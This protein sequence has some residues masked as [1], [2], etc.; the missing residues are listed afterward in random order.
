MCYYVT[1]FQKFF[2]K[3]QYSDVCLHH[4]VLIHSLVGGH[5]YGFHI[6]A[7]VNSAA[8][9]IYAQVFV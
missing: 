9:N 5:F 4:T 2:F 6:L 7:I 8:M 3:E 1:V